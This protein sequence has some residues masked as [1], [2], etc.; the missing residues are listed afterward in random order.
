MT[1]DSHVEDD[2]LA[3]SEDAD[4]WDDKAVAIERRP[5]GTQVV[6]VRLPDE[7][8]RA[9]FRLAKARGVR[10]S[11]LL[12]EAAEHILTGEMLEAT[13]NVQSGRQVQMAAA[14]GAGTWATS[15]PLVTHSHFDE[16]EPYGYVSLGS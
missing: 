9:L 8:A 3:H 11:Q 7:L 4:E 15:N 13:A 1:Q 16:L 10:P 12:R 6:S 5:S 14:I 2:V